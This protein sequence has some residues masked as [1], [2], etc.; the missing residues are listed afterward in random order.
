MSAELPVHW[1]ELSGDEERAVI[2][3]SVCRTSN[4]LRRRVTCLGYLK[5]FNK[6]RMRACLFLWILWDQTLGMSL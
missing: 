4:D 5:T 6:L 1:V 2:V 3:V